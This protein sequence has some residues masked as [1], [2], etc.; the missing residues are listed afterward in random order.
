M[1]RVV[2]FSEFDSYFARIRQAPNFVT[3]AILDTNILISLTYEVKANHDEVVQFFDDHLTPERDRGFRFFSTVST[4]SEFLDFN[5][6]LIMTER[7]RDVA[8]EKSTLKIPARAKMYS[9]S[10]GKTQ[11]PANKVTRPYAKMNGSNLDE[12]AL[13]LQRHQVRWA[14]VSFCHKWLIIHRIGG[15]MRWVRP[16]SKRGAFRR[17]LAMAK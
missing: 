7:L 9:P 3:G 2:S 10:D 4:R 14:R 5:R 15:Q 8:D 1:G 16:M 11:R 17:V 6:R 12:K 13:E